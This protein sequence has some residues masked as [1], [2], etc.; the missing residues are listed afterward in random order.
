MSLHE[1]ARGN[2]LDLLKELIATGSNINEIDKYRRTPL[3]IAAWSGNVEALQTL[4]RANAKI[5]A[6]AMDGF[7]ALHFAAQSNSVSASECIK[8]LVKKQK[9]L[10]HQRVA[11]GSKT[12][13]HLAVAKGNDITV[14]TLL[15]LGSDI[16]AK[17]G[18]GQSVHDLAKS[19]EV[20]ELLQ[21]YNKN[22]TQNADLETKTE[23]SSTETVKPNHCERDVLS[24]HST[25]TS[26]S[27]C[28][29]LILSNEN[30]L[31]ANKKRRLEENF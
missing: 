7:T 20:K 17:T 8:V 24:G 12:A 9:S 25:E 28:D 21:L 10:L 16:N 26:N 1:Q 19:P 13:L 5:D 31:S 4:I 22:I 30:G 11:K 6:V 18:A 23:S 29:E 2:N 14:S 27:T 15:E 3:H